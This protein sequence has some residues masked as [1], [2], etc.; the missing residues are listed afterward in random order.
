MKSLANHFAVAVIACLA[1]STAD[2]AL[3]ADGQQFPG[4]T[5]TCQGCADGGGDVTG[6]CATVCKDKTVY[7][8]GSEPHDYCKKAGRTI[9]GNNLRAALA[10]GGLLSAD[11]ARESKV[12]PS[13]IRGMEASGKKPVRANAETVD[14]VVRALEVKGVEITEDGVRLAQKPI[15]AKKQ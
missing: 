1:G 2:L 4:V 10:L 6:D 5:C 8:K 15:D 11:V 13:I 9:T 12:S 3:A 14:K 7:S